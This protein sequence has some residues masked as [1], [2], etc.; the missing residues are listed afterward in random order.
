M[1]E[2]AELVARHVSPDGELVWRIERE[3]EADGR[4][5]V[6]FGFEGLDWHLHPEFFL[7]N[8]REPLAVALDVTEDLVSDSSIVVISR[9]PHPLRPRE[10]KMSHDLA[11]NTTSS[12]GERSDFTWR[13][14]G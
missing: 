6:S 2:R 9:W 7:A 8:G 12:F 11:P 1:S 14:P 5:V 10:V 4:V 3:V 13:R